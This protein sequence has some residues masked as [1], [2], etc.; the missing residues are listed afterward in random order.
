MQETVLDHSILDVVHVN[1]VF[2]YK[3]THIKN[4]TYL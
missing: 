3:I 4:V 1:I 2:Q